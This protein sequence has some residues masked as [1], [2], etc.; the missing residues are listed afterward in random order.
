M[1]DV[2]RGLS[3]TEALT[4]LLR[5]EG[6]FKS[7]VVHVTGAHALPA[8]LW[9]CRQ[10]FDH[11]GYI[12]PALGSLHEEADAVLIAHTCDEIQ[13]K[14]LLAS[15]RSVKAGGVL[16]FQLHGADDQAWGG[17]DWLL[18][19]SGFTLE[20]SLPGERR[21]LFVARRIAALSRRAA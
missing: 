5:Q 14:H 13:L 15:T 2:S 9:L 10:G 7:S 6:V 1:S 16:I 12:R 3:Q 21:T 18:R 19:S 11:V 4:A 20:R 8:L 17:V